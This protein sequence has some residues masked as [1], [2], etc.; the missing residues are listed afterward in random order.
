MKHSKIEL[1][2]DF[3]GGEAALTPSE[4]SALSNFFKQRKLELKKKTPLR[5]RKKTPLLPA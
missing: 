1:D 3:I 2:V 4:E 5:S